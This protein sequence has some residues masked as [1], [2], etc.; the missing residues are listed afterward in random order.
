M[1][2]P[3][4]LSRSDDCDG[5]TVFIVVHGP[6]IADALAEGLCRRGGRVAILSDMPRTG[7]SGAAIVPTRFDST[8]SIDRALG[9]AVDQVGWPDCI[10]HA[11][12]PASS[13]RPQP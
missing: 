13:L 11:A 6:V 9:E 5:L 7:S 8:Q 1:M 4:H 3:A 2:K 12:A 10:I